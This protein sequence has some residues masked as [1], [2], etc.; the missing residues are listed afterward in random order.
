VVFWRQLRG[1]AGLDKT[2]WRFCN[3]PGNPC[4]PRRH[5]NFPNTLWLLQRAEYEISGLRGWWGSGNRQT[6]SDR[7]P[8]SRSSHRP[9]K[10]RG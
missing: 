5:S 1:H 7:P 9:R 10:T 3:K 8:L 6:R 4:G 2:A